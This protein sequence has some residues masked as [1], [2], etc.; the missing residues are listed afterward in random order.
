MFA[1][2]VANPFTSGKRIKER[3]DA[4][5]DQALRERQEREQVRQAQWGTNSR[6][7]ELARDLNKMSLNQKKS[8]A[9]DR[10]KYQFEADSED[11][12]SLVLLCPLFGL[13]DA[14][15]GERNRFQLGPTSWSRKASE[16][17]CGRNGQRS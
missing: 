7:Q 17:P 1:V 5:L 10:A 6:Q 4:V 15:N 9:A 2:H 12:A 11:E 16:H 14:G 3:E 13:I 8:S